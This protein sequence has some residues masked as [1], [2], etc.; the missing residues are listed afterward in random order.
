MHK[1]IQSLKEKPPLFSEENIQQMYTALYKM[2][3]QYYPPIANE[4]EL[5]EVILASTNIEFFKK[6]Q[7]MIDYN[8]VCRNCYF[9]VKGL[10][11]SIHIQDGIEKTQWFMAEQDI[12]IAV[13]SFFN[14]TPAE[15]RLVALEDTICISLNFDKLEEI[16]LKFPV[17][18]GVGRKL[19]E[20]YYQ[21]AFDRTTWVTLSAKERYE[22]LL[23]SPVYGRFINRVPLA[24]LASYLGID[25][26][27]LSRIRTDINKKR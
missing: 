23:D 6:R 22:R 13:Y 18:N 9:A 17:F 27:T 25:K 2:M 16:Y 10:V 1:T 4:R 26:A 5:L 12:I 11:R 24:A 8:Q 15:E 19:T 7:V 21:L 3:I 14:Q 20:Y